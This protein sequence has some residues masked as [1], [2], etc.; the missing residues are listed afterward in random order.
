MNR[1]PPPAVRGYSY[2]DELDTI[3]DRALTAH[4]Y[5]RG[6]EITPLDALIRDLAVARSDAVRMRDHAHLFDAAGFC[7]VCGLGY[8]ETSP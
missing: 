4:Q 2:Q 1:R 8:E 5:H 7:T 3:L 6:E